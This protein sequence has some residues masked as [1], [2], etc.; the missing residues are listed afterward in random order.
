M[1]WN[2]MGMKPMFTTEW[3]SED[4]IAAQQVDGLD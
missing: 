3:V 2:I 1:I 4:E